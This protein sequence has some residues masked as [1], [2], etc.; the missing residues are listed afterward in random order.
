MTD[1]VKRTHTEGEIHHST[2]QES[3][4]P[5]SNY[6][7]TE[8]AHCIQI[9]L[10]AKGPIRVRPREHVRQTQ[11]TPAGPSAPCGM[12][13]R[14]RPRE[15]NSGHSAK[16]Q[17]LRVIRDVAA[18]QTKD[19]ALTGM[20]WALETRPCILCESAR[21]TDDET[22]SEHSQT[23]WW[24]RLLA[25]NFITAK[26]FI[27]FIIIKIHL[28]NTSQQCVKGRDPTMTDRQKKLY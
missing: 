27:A 25:A 12:F 1:G 28:W 3:L 8:Q 11:Q 13:G 6:W 17:L 7:C 5:R 15:G 20:H 19:S 24:A 9:R 14:A 2:S 21:R 4:G 26:W 22:A 18:G 16:I 23:G 10:S